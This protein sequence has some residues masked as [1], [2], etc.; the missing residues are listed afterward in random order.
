MTA[1]AVAAAAQNSRP[2]ELGA[3]IAPQI[4]VV[5]KALNEEAKIEACLRSVFAEL[6]RLNC[7][8]EVILADSVSSDRTVEKA[9][10]FPVKVVQ[11]EHIHERGCGAG[12][13]LGYQ[14][15]SGEFVLFLD[16]DMTLQAGFLEAGLKALRD[17]AR[18]GGV[19]GLLVDTCVRN[20][21]DAH[22][23]NAAVSNVARDEQWLNGGGLYRR[24]AI[25]AAGGY[26]ANRN[27]KG[28]EEADLGMRVR[29][30]GWRLQ[31]IA[32]PAVLHEGH[33]VST[34][35][36]LRSLWRSG[37][38][39]SSGVLLKQAWGHAWF[40]DALRLLVHP[41]A[42]IVWWMLGS[43]CLAGSAAL[44]SSG[45]V[46]LWL[47]LSLLPVIGMMLKKRSAKAG[48]LS[49]AMW[50][51]WALGLLCGLPLK[52]CKPRQ[53]LASREI[54]RQAGAGQALPHGAEGRR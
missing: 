37:R 33:A 34:A 30:A 35:Q 4:S 18:L 41:V 1:A 46:Q 50:H 43:V 16:G 10:Q 52:T 24:A 40:G 19:A 38:A 48:A 26:A 39:F 54:S 36:L 25:T 7:S 12:V 31:R 20:A 2:I 27:L 5:I 17:D 47:G 22:R 53:A 45:P 51:Y 21:F 32:T 14:H 49:V 9:L 29:A 42:T 3:E 23:V 8:H 15:S 13:Q 28:W 11:F 44:G 6:G